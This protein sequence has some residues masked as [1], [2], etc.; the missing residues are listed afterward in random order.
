MMEE[1]HL[2]LPLRLNVASKDEGLVVEAD[3]MVFVEFVLLAVEY[4]AARLNL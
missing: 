1:E 4:L 2:C 3:A